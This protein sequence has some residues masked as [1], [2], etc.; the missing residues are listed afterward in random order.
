MKENL[1]HA[2][3]LA[4]EKVVKMRIPYGYI[5]EDRQFVL[6]KSKAFVVRMI[7]TYYLAEASLGKVT[8]LFFEKGALSPQKWKCNIDYNR[9]GNPRKTARY[10]P[11][12]AMWCHLLVR[13]PLLYY[14]EKRGDLMWNT[15]DI[16][17]GC[18]IPFII[19]SMM[20]YASRKWNRP[21]L[22]TGCLIFVLIVIRIV[23]NIISGTFFQTFK[24]EVIIF[25]CLILGA[26]IADFIYRIRSK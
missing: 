5:L 18:F 15:I 17:M 9:A 8:V 14:T 1:E 12:M 24:I 13:V 26:L 20:R 4:W 25:A 23:T 3:L 2:H 22:I 10:T 6:N 7:F 21:L 16:I 19:G 11:D